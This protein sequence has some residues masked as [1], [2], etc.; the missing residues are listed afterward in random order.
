M[1]RRKRKHRADTRMVRSPQVHIIYPPSRS[2][3][4]LL[5]SAALSRMRMTVHSPPRDP[6]SCHNLSKVD[7][8]LSYIL[9]A[10]RA[11]R[12]RREDVHVDL[13]VSEELARVAVCLRI[14]LVRIRWVGSGRRH[15]VLVRQQH[16][17]LL[18]GS[19]APVPVPSTWPSQDCSSMPRVSRH[20][21][22]T[23]IQPM[24]TH[25]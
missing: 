15:A 3:Y 7:A 2:L 12:H 23:P 11:S 19:M 1:Q 22:S 14:Y 17:H 4:P 13:Q 8:K 10:S 18:T 9:F 6:S 16:V 5:H 21:A 24:R 20:Q 25:L